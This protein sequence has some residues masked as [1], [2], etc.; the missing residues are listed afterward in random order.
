ML[1]VLLLIVLGLFGVCTYCL[2]FTDH[3]HCIFFVLITVQRLELV[4]KS[5]PN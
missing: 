4:K 3:I 5:N 1:P 2:L